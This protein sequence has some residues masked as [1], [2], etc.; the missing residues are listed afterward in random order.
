VGAVGLGVLLKVV[1]VSTAAD[2]S[3]LLAAGVV[4]VLGFAILPYKK[5]QAKAELR[6]K[7]EDLRQR[8]KR[9]LHEAFER[10]LN[11]SVDRLRD[12]LAPYSRFVRAEHGQLQGVADKLAEV[13]TRLH[14]LRREIEA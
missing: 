12:S 7:I 13:Q 1:L 10:E 3:G 9:V 5:R 11:S 8:L 2:V 4:G 6:D 14:T